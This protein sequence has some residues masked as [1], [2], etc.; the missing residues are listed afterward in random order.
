MRGNLNSNIFNNNL[1]NSVRLNNIHN[2]YPASFLNKSTNAS[3]MTN[4]YYNPKLN[5]TFFIQFST[6]QTYKANDNPKNTFESTLNKFIKANFN[7]DIRDK[8]KCAVCNATKIDFKKSLL[9]NNI[10]QD[11]RV[12]CYI[13]EYKEIKDIHNSQTIKG[14]GFQIY[15][16]ISKA[17][18]DK[19]GNPTTN[20]DSSIVFLNVGN[21]KGFNM[22]G[23]FDGHERNGDLLSQFC[24]DY[25]IVKMNIF[26]NQC[27]LEHISTPEGI[28]DKLKKT[29][30]QF[31]KDCFKNVDNE[32]TKQ[33]NFEYN[34]SGA[35]CT[36][37][38]QLNKLLICANVGNTRAILIFDNGTHT[39]QG[40][41]TLSEDHTPYLPQEKKRIIDN[42]GMI[43]NFKDQFG[44][45]DPICRIF[46]VGQNFPGLSITR[47][48]GHF[49]GK[50]I[51]VSNEPHIIDLKKNH[52][53]KYMVIA[54]EGIWKMLKNEDI[55]NFGNIYYQ[56]GQI[57]Q[58]CKDLVQLA[59]EKW[60]T[61]N[62][63]RNDIT[64]V[65]VYF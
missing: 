41:F 39:N 2:Y 53:F 36:L 38:I 11:S 33:K 56:K 45:I 25:F 34:F 29:N 16:Q 9:E 49:M 62:I 23:V 60:R 40:I 10:N 63:D 12:F 37:V 8:I 1:N 42:K 43:G 17:G 44:N 50:E 30:F 31:I 5:I 52:K 15:G 22:F 54:S 18:K 51:G 59:L 4:S 58:F 27:K 61:I 65:C 47:A 6:G 24:R 64:V 35:S 3:Y 55:R 20:Q 46:K 13:E 19:N 32:M 26:A 48:F 14:V 28:Y 57:K 7:Q 21:I